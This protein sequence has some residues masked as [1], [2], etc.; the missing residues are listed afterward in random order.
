MHR[1][2]PGSKLTLKKLLDD[3]YPQYEL[4]SERPGGPQ[5]VMRH[6]NPNRAMNRRSCRFWVS[7]IGGCYRGCIAFVDW[8]ICA[9]LR[10][11]CAACCLL[12]RA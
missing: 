2:K 12:L 6:P 4:R 5:Y 7:A 10:V 1:V 3:F 9:V 8:V 11:C